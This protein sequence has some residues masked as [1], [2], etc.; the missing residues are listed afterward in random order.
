MLEIL[1]GASYLA[2]VLG[3]PAAL[4]IYMRDRR[5]E[6]AVRYREAYADVDSAYVEFMKLCLENADIAVLREEDMRGVLSSESLDA[7]MRRKWVLYSVLISVFERAFVTFHD[8]PVE[9]RDHQWDGWEDYALDYLRM[10]EFRRVWDAIGSNFDERFYA[11]M[12]S[13]LSRRNP[14][15][16]MPSTAPVLDPQD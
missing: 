11:H 15:G 1:E 2:T 9:L 4:F 12:E 14:A 7:D 6:R 3:I 16:S 8:C 13:S 10:P 5:R